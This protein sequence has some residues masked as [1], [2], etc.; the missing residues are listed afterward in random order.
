MVI[1]WLL[2]VVGELVDVHFVIS[3]T[4]RILN[5]VTKNIAV[6]VDVGFGYLN[7]RVLLISPLMSS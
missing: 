1:L 7:E 2:C 5:D 6:I 3:V 4:L